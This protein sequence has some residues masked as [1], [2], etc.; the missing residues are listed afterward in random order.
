MS[1]CIRHHQASLDKGTRSVAAAYKPPMLAPRQLSAGVQ[2]LLARPE[3]GRFDQQRD[4]TLLR[5]VK[6]WV[7]PHHSTNTRTW[8]GAWWSAVGCSKWATSTAASLRDP[9]LFGGRAQWISSPSPQ[10][11]CPNLCFLSCSPVQDVCARASTLTGRFFF[12]QRLKQIDWYRRRYQ[13]SH[14]SGQG[15]CCCHADGVYSQLHVHGHTGLPHAERMW[16]H[17]TM[18]PWHGDMRLS[19]N[20]AAGKDTL[21]DASEGPGVSRGASMK[22]TPGGRG[23]FFVPLEKSS[24]GGPRAV[25]DVLCAAILKQGVALCETKKH[26][27]AQKTVAL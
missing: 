22:A 25:L 10:P 4:T 24:S 13:N 18:C 16:Y 7:L 3:K 27:V 17:Y 15:P 2:S 1:C 5:P 20:L 12:K 9:S 26:F 21:T 8:Q 11:L 23:N 6:W 19:F 14:D